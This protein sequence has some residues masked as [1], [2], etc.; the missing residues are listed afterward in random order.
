MHIQNI[1]LL[2]VKTVIEVT[3]FTL[4]RET[5][6]IFP[7]TEKEPLG[8]NPNNSFGILSDGSDVQYAQ[9]VSSESRIAE[10]SAA[11]ARRSILEICT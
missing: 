8:T 7:H 10:R 4:F 5:E 2:R 3:V 1:I 6:L 11:I 9:D